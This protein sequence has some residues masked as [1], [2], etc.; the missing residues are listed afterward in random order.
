[1][2]SPPSSQSGVLQDPQALVLLGEVDVAAGVDQ[3]VL[4]L[5]DQLLG[6][7]SVPP[8]GIG[9]NEVSDLARQARVRDVD[10]SQARV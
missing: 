3:H 10:D 5:H 6:Q 1:M 9:G 8:R 2:I 4:T 7:R